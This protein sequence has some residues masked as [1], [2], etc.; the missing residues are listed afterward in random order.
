[1]SMIKTASASS[2]KESK[3]FSSVSS[4]SEAK[5]SGEKLQASASQSSV[6][7]SLSQTS[8][9]GSSTQSVY[10][11][12]YDAQVL[13]PI[14][15]STTIPLLDDATLTSMAQSKL[16]NK[17]QEEVVVRRGEMS[18]T[19]EMVRQKSESVRYT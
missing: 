4:S 2:Y 3:Q 18:R 12:M 15:S 11:M 1:M 13:S 16:I 5:V 6:G 9:G 8:I 7:H 14:M 19:N 10:D 17:S